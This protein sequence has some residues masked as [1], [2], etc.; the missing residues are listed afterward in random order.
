MANNASTG[1]QIA[2]ITAGIA[3]GILGS[4]LLPPFLAATNNA[5]RVRAGS[6]PFEMLIEDHRLI[7][8]FLEEMEN[9]PT[10]A[11]G[12]R[13]AAFLGLKRKLGKHALA[14]EDVVYPILHGEAHHEEQSKE[15][16]DEHADMKIALYELETLLKSGADWREQVRSLR[17]LIQEHI[18]E[19][20]N[21]VFPHLRQL[22]DEQRA[23]KVSGQIGREEA[24]IL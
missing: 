10:E 16:Y 24:L 20:E 1:R 19:E 6:D 9:A 2:L 23:P 15:L 4:R 21:V 12:R 18:D 17:L 14:E 11:I 3:A 7:L 8:G 5:R 13:S 22:L